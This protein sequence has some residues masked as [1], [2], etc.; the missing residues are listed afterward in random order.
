MRPEVYNPG[1]AALAPGSRFPRIPLLDESGAP[2]PA[3]NG[4]TLYAVFKTTCPVCELT[5]PYLERIRQFADGGNVR[6]LAITQDDVPKT[7]AYNERLGTHIATL[8]DPPPWKASDALGLTNVPTLFRVNP[9]GTV[10]ETIVGFDREA[11]RGLAKRAL[12]A[13]G[14][15][16]EELFRPEEKVPPIRPG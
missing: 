2:S 8:Y 15:P 4:E 7:R 6:V 11:M 9:D 12:A 14:K 13:A 10:A 5:W 16:P 1:V 3:A